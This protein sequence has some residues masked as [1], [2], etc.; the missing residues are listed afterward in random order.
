MQSSTQKLWLQTVPRTLWGRGE[1]QMIWSENNAKCSLTNTSKKQRNYQ[2]SSIDDTLGIG[3]E[4]S[5]TRV[6]RQKPRLQQ[7]SGRN[8]ERV[9][10]KRKS[11]ISP[12]K[13]TELFKKKNVHVS[14]HSNQVPSKV[15]QGFETKTQRQG[16]S[17]GVTFP[18]SAQHWGLK[19]Q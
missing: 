11:L 14:N 10:A 19:Q 1:N 16:G 9:E 18:S 8:E 6:T 4:R 5:S 12:L 15:E 13:V 17:G 3:P 7:C 2:Q